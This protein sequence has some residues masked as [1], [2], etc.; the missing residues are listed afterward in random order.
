[1]MDLKNIVFIYYNSL[2]IRKT[3]SDQFEKT[4][5]N[6][7]YFLLQHIFCWLSLSI[8]YYCNF[9]SLKNYILHIM[10][11]SILE[12]HRNSKILYSQCIGCRV[13]SKAS[14]KILYSNI[15]K[16]DSF[17][18]YSAFYSCFIG[19]TMLFCIVIH[20]KTLIWEPSLILTIRHEEI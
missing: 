1:M 14:C 12:W 2:S 8:I 3:Y 7:L 17:V 16:F 6:I 10:T 11:I 9:Y 13:P 18:L 20:W 5:S 15:T 4:I 19:L